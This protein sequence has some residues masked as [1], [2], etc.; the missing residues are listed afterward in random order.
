MFSFA[1]VISD[2]GNDILF[3]KL[4]PETRGCTEKH[5]LQCAS[6]ERGFHANPVFF[7]NT[8]SDHPH[9]DALIIRLY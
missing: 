2:V 4:T 3:E 6:G 7:F 9:V 1:C 8:F 5:P